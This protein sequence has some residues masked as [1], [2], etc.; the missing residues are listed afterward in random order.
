MKRHK[1]LYSKIYDMDNLKLAHQ[2]ARRKKTFYKEVVEVDSNPEFYLGLIQEMLMNCDYKTSQYEKFVKRDSG[3]E[4]VIYKLPYFPDRI[5]QWAIIQVLEPIFL[6]KLMSCT[7]SAIPKRGGRTA[8]KQLDRYIRKGNSKY[9]LKLDISKFYPSINH[10]ML[11]S[12]YSG[13]FKD[14]E[15]LNLL[16]EIIDSCE[17]GIPIGNYL[18]QYS[19]NL[20]LSQLDRYLKQ[21]LR[22]KSYVRYMDDMVILSDSKEYLHNILSK[23]RLKTRSMD[24]KL[25]SNYRIFPTKTG[26]DFVGH[27]HYGNRVGLRKGIKRRMIRTIGEINN[28]ISSDGYISGKDISRVMSYKGWVSVGDCRNLYRKY[29]IPMES[30]IKKNKEV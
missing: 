4:R 28:N 2:N 12:M 16:N 23:I 7:H 22:I 8:F 9:C 20:Y 24:L 18:S 30:L 25:K 26:V 5:V 29:I 21:D 1:G 27:V 10:D 14:R 11:K 3:K 19:G 17:T 6:N 15:L 13:Y